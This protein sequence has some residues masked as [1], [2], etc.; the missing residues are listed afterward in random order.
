MAEAEAAFEEAANVAHTCGLRLFE[1]FAVSLMALPW[2][3][4]VL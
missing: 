4:T 3:R 1:L 2:L